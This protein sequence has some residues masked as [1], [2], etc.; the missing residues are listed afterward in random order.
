MPPAIRRTT[1]LALVAITMLAV[2]G[3]A[4]PAA[5]HGMR[6]AY[7][8]LTETA[9]GHAHVAIRGKVPMT[10]VALTAAAPCTLER[11]ALVC[12]RLAGATLEVTGLG[13]IASEAVVLVNFL[14]GTATSACVTPGAPRWTIPGA[15][16][17]IVSVARRYVALGVVHIATGA[18]H[19]LFLLALVLCLRSLRAV[20]LAETAFTLSHTLSFSASALGW[21]HVSA[22]AAEACIAVSLVLA[23][24]DI[25]RSERVAPWR[26]AGLAFAFGLVHGLGFAGGLA[27]IGLPATAVTAALAGFA[28]GVELGQVVF[29]V[30]AVG[31][32]RLVGRVPALARATAHAGTY[33]VGGVGAFCLCE[34]LG[35]LV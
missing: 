22:A 14:D 4:R 20:M 35:A 28:T 24:L 12:P 2:L 31:A 32:L 21:V 17:G 10:G 19:L 1:G 18:D 6:T 25:G 9:P 33:A 3:P 26:S 16:D 15:A 30:T 13:P 23:A 11:D 34:R 29:L 8:E 5:A 27:E 7:L